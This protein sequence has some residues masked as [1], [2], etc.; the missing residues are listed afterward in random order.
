ML[1]V[2]LGLLQKRKEGRRDSDGPPVWVFTY[3]QTASAL[4]D[5]EE[6]RAPPP[7]VIC[8]NRHLSRCLL[9]DAFRKGKNKFRINTISPEKIRIRPGDGSYEL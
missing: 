9:L 7:K 5:S 2:F 1:V 8:T 4:H 3:K 6:L